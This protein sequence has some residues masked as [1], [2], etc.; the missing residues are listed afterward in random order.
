MKKA[1]LESGRRYGQDKGRLPDP[2]ADAATEDAYDLSAQLARGEDKLYRVG[3]YL[4]VHTDGD[5]ELADETAAV[6][7]FAAPGDWHCS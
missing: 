1:R 2:H 3:L 5:E 6:R 7:A 4:T